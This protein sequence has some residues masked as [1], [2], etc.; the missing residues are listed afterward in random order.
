MSVGMNTLRLHYKDCL[1]GIGNGMSKRIRKHEFAELWIYYQ[2]RK[3]HDVPVTRISKFI[4]ETSIWIKHAIDV[5]TKVVIFGVTGLHW[6]HSQW[7][8]M[9]MTHKMFESKHRLCG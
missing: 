1:R 3:Q 7:E 9:I 5:G 2:R 4:D 8:T 6:V